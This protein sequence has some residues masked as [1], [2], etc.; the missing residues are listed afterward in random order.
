LPTLLAAVSAV[1]V[2]AAG[3]TQTFPS[4]PHTSPLALTDDYA[5]SALTLAIWGKPDQICSMGDFLRMTRCSHEAL[6]S[7]RV[8]HSQQDLGD[9]VGKLLPAPVDQNPF[10]NLG[11]GL[12]S[13]HA[14]LEQRPGAA[15]PVATVVRFIT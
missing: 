12:R 14:M 9:L 4:N 6:P 7:R 15:Y 2:P 10:W 11:I 1:I 5:M 3:S 13:R 8:A